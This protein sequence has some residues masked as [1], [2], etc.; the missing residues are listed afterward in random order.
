MWAKALRAKAWKV[1]A[2]ALKAKALGAKAWKVLEFAV[3]AFACRNL[4]FSSAS[5]FVDRINTEVLLLLLIINNLI[6]TLMNFEYVHTILQANR[7]RSNF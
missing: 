5:T 3:A 1:W 2:T 4:D 6:S 7:R